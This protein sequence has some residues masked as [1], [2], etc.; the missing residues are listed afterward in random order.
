MLSDSSHFPSVCFRPT[1]DKRLALL[2]AVRRATTADTPEAA[3]G[4]AGSISSCRPVGSISK[5]MISDTTSDLHRLSKYPS[6]WA[7]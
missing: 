7:A 5:I 3:V 1:L 2:S 6:R 4:P